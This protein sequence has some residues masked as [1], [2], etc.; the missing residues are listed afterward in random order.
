MMA[1]KQ[2]P[3]L[4]PR[5]KEIETEECANCRKTFDPLRTTRCPRCGSPI[6]NF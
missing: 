1:E 5:E 6:G 2:E 4:R 3:A